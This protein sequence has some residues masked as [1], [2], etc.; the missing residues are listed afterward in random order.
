MPDNILLTTDIHLTEKSEDEYKFELF[1]WIVKKFRKEVSRV[2]I[3]GDITD[4]KNF[5]AD[6]FVNRIVDNFIYLS[7]YFSVYILRG[8]HDYD[9]EPSSPFFEFLNDYDNI[10]YFIE[11]T[12]TEE[13]VLFL[14]HSRDPGNDWGILNTIEKPRA[15]LMHQTFRGAISES[16]F[17]LDGLSPRRFEKYQCPIYSGDIHVPQMVGPVMY[18]GSPYHT[19]YGDKFDPRLVLTDKNFLPLNCDI[20]FPAPKK[21]VIEI[22]DAKHLKS[23]SFEKG[24][25]AK[26]RLFLPKSLYSVW[27]EQRDEIRRIA[28]K[29]GLRLHSITHKEL[30]ETKANRVRKIKRTKGKSRSDIFSSFCKRYEIRSDLV[31]AGK[32]FME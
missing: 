3:L 4:R 32:T 6:F 12:F 31:E 14:P 29:S 5:H 13:R 25:R 27:P 18:V 26:V 10:E 9:A 30:E 2:C 20:K 8:N 15:I 7:K 1:P 19:R 17:E 11:P 23:A 16:G 22:T 21:L 28:E 24:D